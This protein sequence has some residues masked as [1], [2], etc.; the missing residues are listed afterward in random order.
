M[1]TDEDMLKAI[2]RI[3]RTADGALQYRWLQKQLLGVPGTV[4]PNVLTVHHGER[5]F[6]AQLMGLMSEAIAEQAVE[7][8]GADTSTNDPTGPIVFAARVPAGSRRVTA[9]EFLA[10]QSSTDA[11]QGS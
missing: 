9:R 10:A 3:A 7:R 2:A 5:R 4:D 8:P 11:A 6:A 1:I